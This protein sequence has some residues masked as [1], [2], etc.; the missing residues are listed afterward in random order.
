MRAKAWAF[1]LLNIQV[2]SIFG[3]YVNPI[4]LENIGW[5][6]Y[7]YYCVWVTI[8]FIIVY[9][10]FVETAGPTLEELTYLF[11]GESAKMSVKQKMQ[12]AKEDQEQVEE[13][14]L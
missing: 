6:F 14:P 10:F 5:K 8:I 12:D 13:R 1:V 3:G 4:G 2:S 7:I 11:E 9:F